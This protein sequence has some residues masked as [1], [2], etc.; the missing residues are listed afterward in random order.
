MIEAPA[1][2]GV[3]DVLAIGSL[4][5]L[6]VDALVTTR[7]GGV[8]AG[9]YG[10]LNLATHVGDDPD[11]VAENRRRLAD[12]M[13][14]AVANLA[15]AT[16]V[17]GTDAA[18]TTT[19]GELGEA[20]VI[21]TTSD[22]VVACILVADCA[23]LVV[24]DPDARVLVVAHAGW[25]G[26]AAGVAGAAVDAAVALG[27]ARDRCHAAIGP[28]ISASA[29]EVGDEVV[30]AFVDAGCDRAVRADGDGRARVG[31]TLAN[32]IQLERAGIAAAR[33]STSAHATDGGTTWFSDRAQRP[34]GR[35]A[36]VAR[37]M[38]TAS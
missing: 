31:I 6:G 7:A 13:G 15:F 12:A 28:C 27:A 8:S 38:R 29:Y 2:R 30:S 37:I 24:V 21:A 20:D 33:I 35:F 9:P 14:V 25:R 34:C 32:V 26:T 3:L 36:L 11:C 1:R 16:Q 23:P 18:V 22:E 5:R 4:A 10:T 17:H 19:G